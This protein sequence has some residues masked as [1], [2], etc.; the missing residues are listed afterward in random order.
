MTQFASRN[1]PILDT[2]GFSTAAL[3]ITTELLSAL[4]AIP[5]NANAA[6]IQGSGKALFGYRMDGSRGESAA[7]TLTADTI[8]LSNRG[9]IAAFVVVA[10]GG[11]TTIVVQFFTGRSGWAY[12]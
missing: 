7:D 11:A 3:P 6:T 12:R 4:V 8:Y 9:E 5:D 10:K 2:P 1:T